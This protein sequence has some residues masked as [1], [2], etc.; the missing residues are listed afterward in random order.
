[1][2]S[3]FRTCKSDV[4]DVN[5]NPSD[6]LGFFFVLNEDDVF[7]YGEETK[8]MAGLKKPEKCECGSTT[9][10]REWQPEK[11]CCENGHIVVSRNSK[12]QTGICTKCCREKS[13]QVEFKPGK[14]LCMDCYNQY[15]KDWNNSKLDERKQYKRSYYVKNRIRLRKQMNDYW[16]GGWEQYLSDRF[17]GT[18]K[19]AK[20]RFDGGT[21]NLDFTI[22][23]E[24]LFELAKKQD[25]KCAITGVPMVHSWGDVKSASIDRID[26]SKGYIPENVQLVCKCINL[27]KNQNK[28]IDI[29]NFLDE[30]CKLQIRQGPG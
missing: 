24:F 3:R 13:E 30:Y 11:W 27:M 9:L 28:D 17:H 10:H 23:R 25:Y 14:N 22:S 5:K 29:K 2:W 12:P 8:S 19:T 1:V 20:K 18:Q 4:P 16:Q 6:E 26:S 21:R 15:M 7:D